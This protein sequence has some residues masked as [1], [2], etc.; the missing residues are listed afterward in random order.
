MNFVNLCF[1]DT[2]IKEVK[3]KKKIVRKIKL[4][5]FKKLNAPLCFKIEFHISPI[6]LCSIHILVLNS[7]SFN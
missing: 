4:K 2:H 3:S 6:F 7:D 1:K 5:T